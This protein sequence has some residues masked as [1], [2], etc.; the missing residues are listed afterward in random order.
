MACPG[1]TPPAKTLRLILGDQLNPLYPWF[2]QV[3]AGLVYV[4]M[5]TRPCAPHPAAD[6]DWQ[7]C[8]AGRS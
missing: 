1:E 6:G 2:A 7:L 5:E 3:D 4:L 8:A